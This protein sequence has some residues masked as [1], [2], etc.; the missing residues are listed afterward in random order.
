MLRVHKYVDIWVNS[1][2]QNMAYMVTIVLLAFQHKLN[3]YYLF[4]F[5]N[6][7]FF[8]CAKI[9]IKSKISLS[10]FEPHTSKD[11]V[12]TLKWFR[13]TRLSH[14]TKYIT[15]IIIY[16]NYMS[17]FSELKNQLPKLRFKI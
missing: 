14:N 17:K 3:Y 9:L 11:K 5:L 1:L 8:I 4:E 2:C 15:F 13:P 6:K 12:L 16:K 7:Y 10:R